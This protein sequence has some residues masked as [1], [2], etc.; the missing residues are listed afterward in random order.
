MVGDYNRY[1]CEFLTEND[2]NKAKDLAT[3]AYEEA[4]ALS[5]GNLVSTNPI[6]LGLM[7]NY[8]VFVYEILLNT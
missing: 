1:L 5:K 8:S 6:R 2:H 3:K 4:E 7:L